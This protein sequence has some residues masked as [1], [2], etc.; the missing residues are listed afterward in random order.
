VHSWGDDLADIQP[1]PLKRPC[2]ACG[3]AERY[4]DRL[5]LCEPCRAEYDRETAEAEAQ[6][7]AD[8]DA[9]ARRSYYNG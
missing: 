7:R 6:D 4:L 8:E 5:S 1:A 2:A 9:A 3:R